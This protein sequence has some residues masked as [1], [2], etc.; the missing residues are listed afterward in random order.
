MQSS[1]ISMIIEIMNIRVGKRQHA[2]AKD[3]FHPALDDID[4]AE[5]LAA[6]G[7]QTRL[8]IV[9]RL[10]EEEAECRSGAFTRLASASNLSYHFQK[11]REA[12][13]T[14]T[15]YAGTSKFIRLRREDLDQRFPGLLDAVINSARQSPPIAA[16]AE[17]AAVER[18]INGAADT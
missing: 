15:R 17:L 10:A 12:G 11:L 14:S 7:E 16:M 8:A 6:M 9:L 1:L 5:M 2:M 4:P 18:S 3:L 13:V